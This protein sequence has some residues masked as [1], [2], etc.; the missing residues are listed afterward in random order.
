MIKEAHNII[1]LSS[2]LQKLSNKELEQ[3]VL[4]LKLE[5]EKLELNN[6]KK[7]IIILN[8]EEQ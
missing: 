8:N 5:N 4:K 6:L 1:N 2:Y 7:K 3:I